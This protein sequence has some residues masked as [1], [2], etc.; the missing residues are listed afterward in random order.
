MANTA[1]GQSSVGTGAPLLVHERPALSQES[2]SVGNR[3][4]PYKCSAADWSSEIL[5]L[6]PVRRSFHSAAVVIFLPLFM[7]SGSGRFGYGVAF[8]SSLLAAFGAFGLLPSAPRRNSLIFNSSI[9][10]L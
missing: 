8:A 5:F 9:I 10:R 2:V 1:E 7:T 4:C 3:V 6:N